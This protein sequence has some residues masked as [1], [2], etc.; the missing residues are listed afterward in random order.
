MDEDVQTLLKSWDLEDYDA[1]FT[2]KFQPAYQNVRYEGSSRIL[3]IE[4]WFVYCMCFYLLSTWF[5]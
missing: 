4:W 2:G 5:T 1:I 3:S